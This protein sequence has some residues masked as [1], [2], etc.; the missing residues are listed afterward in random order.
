[1]EIVNKVQSSG[2]ISLDLADYYVKGERI[3]LD[4]KEQLFMGMMLREKEFR[5]FIKEHDWNQ[6]QGKFVAITCS[7]DAIVPTWAYMLIA[8]K[9]T[10]NAGRFIFGSLE[11]LDSLLMIESLR[12]KLNP[13][14]FNGARVVVKG[15][16]EL[17]I[18]ETAYVELTALLRPKV[19]SLLFGE[20]CSTVPIYKKPKVV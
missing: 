12:E 15:C 3:L 14:D 1:M 9:L 11:T 20:P 8:D 16:G 10:E 7:A 19:Q 6:Y 18:T 13:E 17:P 4:I 5:Q 2:I